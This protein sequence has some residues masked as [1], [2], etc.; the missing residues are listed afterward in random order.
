M[1]KNIISFITL[2]LLTWAVSSQ[3]SLAQSSTQDEVT[4]PFRK[5]RWLTGLSGSISSTST[6]LD[7]VQGTNFANQYA[8]ELSTGRFFKDRWLA[9]LTFR[10]ERNSSEEFVVRDSESLF[11][12]PLISHYFSDSKLGSVFI[13]FSPGFTRFRDKT[14]IEQNG[15]VTQ[16]LIKG[17]GF[18][19][20]LNLG[21]SYV[22]HDRIAFDLGLSV[23]SNWINGRRESEPTGENRKE[24]FRVGGIAFSFG[25]NVLL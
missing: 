19:M 9:G 24:N 13:L 8:L 22:V 2:C 10:A 12:G 15:V 14:A 23:S 6:R 25:F 16:E 18:G 5:G 21:Y 7:T 11:I 4:T 20:L 1:P 17:Q 3:E